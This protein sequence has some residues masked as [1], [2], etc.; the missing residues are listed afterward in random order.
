MKT[1]LTTTSMIAAVLAVPA[2]AQTTVITE[3][4][5]SVTAVESDPDTSGGGALGGATSGAIAG[6]AAG[7]PVG[8]A[9]GAAAGAVVGDIG[10]DAMTPEVRTYV[11]ENKTESVMIDGDV[12]VGAQ[13][14]DTV[15]FNTIP[16]SPYSYVYV[17]N[18]PVLIEP[19]TREIVYVYN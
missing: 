12:V 2:F 5:P 6:A 3:T 7:G 11:M 1:I 16:E 19:E 15:E 4:T 9:V 13:V 17:D 10:E 18:Q 14:P 8:A